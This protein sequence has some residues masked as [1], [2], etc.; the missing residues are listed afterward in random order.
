MVS[1]EVRK[2]LIYGWSN[3]QKSVDKLSDFHKDFG[4]KTSCESFVASN[5]T[6]GCHQRY[7]WEMTEEFSSAT[8]LF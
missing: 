5:L 1:R 6:N 2:F 8:L 4:E 3:K 7:V